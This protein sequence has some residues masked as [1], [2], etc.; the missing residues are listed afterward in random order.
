MGTTFQASSKAA[1]APDIE[2]AIYD[3]RFDGIQRPTKP[4][5]PPMMTS[6]TAANTITTGAGSDVVKYDTA[7]NINGDT[8]LDFAGTD[9]LDLKALGLSAATVQWDAGSQKLSHTDADPTQS[10]TLKITGTFDVSQV[11]YT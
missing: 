5:T 2:A 7:A 6:D 4:Q 3:A 8:L 10:W 11:L 1:D 9:Q